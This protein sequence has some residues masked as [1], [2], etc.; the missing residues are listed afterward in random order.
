M[1]VVANPGTRLAPVV[2]RAV[3]AAGVAPDGSRAVNAL[4]RVTLI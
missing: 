1:S 2:L 4:P 3:R